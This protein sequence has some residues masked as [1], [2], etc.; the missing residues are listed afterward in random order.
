MS[1]K[2]FYFSVYLSE[3]TTQEDDV[4]SSIFNKE[5][6]EMMKKIWTASQAWKIKKRFNNERE[7]G[8]E[9]YSCKNCYYQSWL[10][11]CFVALTHRWILVVFWFNHVTM[12]RYLQWKIFLM[13]KYMPKSVVVLL[14]Q[15]ETKPWIQQ[16]DEATMQRLNIWR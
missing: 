3:K 2:P 15:L 14:N 8:I 5:I 16:S 9:N 12:Q 1:L 7:G 4:F 6:N 10:N 13:K 11:R